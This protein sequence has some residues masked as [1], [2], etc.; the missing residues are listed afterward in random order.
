MKTSHSHKADRRI[1]LRVSSRSLWRLTFQEITRWKTSLIRKPC[2]ESTCSNKTQSSSTLTK[3]CTTTLN[4]RLSKTLSHSQRNAATCQ[5]PRANSIWQAATILFSKC[6]LKTPSFW[7]KIDRLLWHWRTWT[8]IDQIML[9]STSKVTSTFLEVWATRTLKIAKWLTQSILARCII[10]PKTSGQR[11][12]VSQMQDK[13]LVYALSMISISS[14]LA[15][16]AL[17]T[18]AQWSAN[19]SILS[20]MLRCMTLQMN[21]GEQST[22]FLTRKSCACWTLDVSKS[23]ARRSWSLEV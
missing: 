10:L 7:M 11:C 5:L 2:L 9:C 18:I 14:S 21:H 6:F 23:L 15:A 4:A 12:Q 13:A 1:K 19:F 22:T 8:R 3:S 17:K 16:N 20:Q